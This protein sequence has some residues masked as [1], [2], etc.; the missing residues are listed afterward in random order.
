MPSDSAHPEASRGAFEPAAPSFSP[1]LNP[2][3][4]EGILVGIL[5]LAVI[6]CYANMLTN[7]FVYDDDQQ[8]LQ[9]PYIKSWHYLPQ[10]FGSTVWSFVGQAGAS[11]YYRPLMTFS[12]LVMWTLF[13]AVPFGFHLLSL[14]LHAAVVLLGFYA[15][16]RLFADWR[17]AWM[18]ALLFAVHPVHTEAVDWISAYPD[19]QV[20]LFFLAAFLWYARPGK[21]TFIDQAILLVFFTLALLSKEP[22]LMFIL[23]AI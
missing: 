5:L 12:F 2:I 7:S 23:V 14:A 9:N 20:A 11:N 6:L 21:P 18:A 15:G 3:P 10:I 19:L 4:Y 16:I 22:A 8:I 1:S 17:L 13:G